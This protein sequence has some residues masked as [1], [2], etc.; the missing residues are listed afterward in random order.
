MPAGQIQPSTLRFLRQLKQHNHR[1]WFEQHREDYQQARA[2][3]T[4]LVAQVIEQFSAADPGIASLEPSKCL[5]R[6]YRDIRFSK[7]KTPY[8]THFAASF[9]RR[10]TRVH[11]PGY[12]LHIEPGGNSFVGGGIWHPF[13]E[14][15]KKI[16]QEIDYNLEEFEA[17]L[18]QPAFKRRFGALVDEEALQRPPKG[19]PAD[20]PGISY[21]K[22]RN[23][24]VGY[25]LSDEQVLSPQLGKQIV[26]SFTLM[27]PFID[28]LS[29]ALD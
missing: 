9:Q 1:S 2:N 13:P 5:F 11:S 8:K 20:H 12:Y 25:N 26:S 28:F 3:V 14:D 22:M 23:F 18:Q 29:R 15:L 6:I 27:K 10:G 19:Y 17:L 7:D 21:L 16:R 24:V 4:Q